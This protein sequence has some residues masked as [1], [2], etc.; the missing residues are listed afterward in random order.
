M[1]TYVM[2]IGNMEYST[3]AESLEEAIAQAYKIF[4][5]NTKFYEVI[6]II[7]HDYNDYYD[8]DPFFDF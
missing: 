6:M 3:D 8:D 2:R 4:L 1:A 5:G 7:P